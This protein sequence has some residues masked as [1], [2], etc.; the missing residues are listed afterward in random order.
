MIRSVII[1]IIIAVVIT[2]AHHNFRQHWMHN[3]YAAYCY[4]R[5]I[6]VCM[7]WSQPWALKKRLNGNFRNWAA[8]AADSCGPKEPCIR[9]GCTFVMQNK[10]F[11]Q[12]VDWLI[13]RIV[14]RC[15]GSL[16]ALVYQ[17]TITPLALPCRLILPE[18]G[19]PLSLLKHG[20]LGDWYLTGLIDLFSV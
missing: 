17:H 9:W 14:W 3:I 20:W 10:F 7:C 16:A 18:L 11:A 13:D 6:I 19:K 8:M 5:N 12:W 15:A 2:V 4:R 1:I